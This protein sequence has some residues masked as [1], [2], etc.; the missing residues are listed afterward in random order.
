MMIISITYCFDNHVSV[1]ELRSL[2]GQDDWWAGSV[3]SA[4]YYIGIAVALHLLFIKCYVL[5]SDQYVFKSRGL[6]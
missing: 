6:Q 2:D 3:W 5:L 1:I 4:R